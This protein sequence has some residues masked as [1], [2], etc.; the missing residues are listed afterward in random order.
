M[1]QD[2]RGLPSQVSASH[3]SPNLN[4]TLGESRRQTRLTHVVSTTVVGWG[5]ET[6]TASSCSSHSL[7]LQTFTAV[8]N[9]PLLQAGTRF[10]TL[11]EPSYL[12]FMIQMRKLRLEL[13]HNKLW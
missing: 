10:S 1:T 3:T 13:A 7:E 11:Q 12:I 6:G 2:K 5:L 8:C 9:E 4:S